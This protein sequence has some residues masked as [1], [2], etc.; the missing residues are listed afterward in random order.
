MCR[1]HGKLTNFV[2]FCGNLMCFGVRYNRLCVRSHKKIRNLV[3]SIAQNVDK[4]HSKSEENLN[5]CVTLCLHMNKIWIKPT[6]LCWNLHKIWIKSVTLCSNSDKL[7]IKDV[8][9]QWKLYIVLTPSAII[10]Y[11]VHSIWLFRSY[12]DGR[13]GFLFYLYVAPRGRWK[14]A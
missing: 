8:T 6:K 9:L 14:V 4:T 2:A 10:H 13:S 11:T 3:L 7:W 12:V 5:K 1:V